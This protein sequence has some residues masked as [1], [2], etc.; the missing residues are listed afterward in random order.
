MAVRHIQENPARAV[1]YKTL[2]ARL[3]WFIGLDEADM[4]LLLQQSANAIKVRTDAIP[5]T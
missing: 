5:C 4:H 3:S 2:I 1:Y